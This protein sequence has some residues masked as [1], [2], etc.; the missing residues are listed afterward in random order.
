MDIKTIQIPLFRMLVE[1]VY[2][3]SVRMGDKECCGKVVKTAPYWQDPAGPVVEFPFKVNN[4]I[5]YGPHSGT[6]IIITGKEY[7]F[8]RPED[9]F[10]IY[11]EQ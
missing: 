8:M 7:F 2:G 3:K 4:L 10:A 9:V 11:T 1:P 6:S 5:I